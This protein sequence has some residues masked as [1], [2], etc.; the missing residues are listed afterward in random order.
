MEELKEI[1]ESK[2]RIVKILKKQNE[3]L[4]AKEREVLYVGSFG[5]GKSLALC[6]K[7]LKHAVI[8]NNFCLLTRK[9]RASLTNSTLRTLLIGET[10]CPPVLPQGSYEYLESKGLI[11][12]YGGSDIAIVGC[13]NSE[14]IRSINAGSIFIDECVELNYDEYLAL[15]GRLRLNSDPNRQICSATN[16]GSL[17]HWLYKRF[18]S[19]TNENRKVIQ[20]SIDDNHFL[21]EDYVK[22][23]KLLTGVNYQRYVLGNFCSNEKAVY[24]DFNPA[25]HIG[26][27]EVGDYTKFVI[28]VDVGF[29]DPTCI[30]VAGYN[31]ESAHVYEEIYDNKLTPTDICNTIIQLKEKYINIKSIV[32]DPSA[33]GT[34]TQMEQ[35]NI[36]NVKKAFNSID[37]GIFRV[38]EYLIK[39]KLTMSSKCINLI[40]EFDIYSYGDKEKPLD[41]DNHAMDSIRYLVSELYDGKQK[42][43]FPKIYV[44]GEEVSEDEEVE[45]EIE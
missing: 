41:V 44:D 11:H 21:P 5:S 1:E 27:K 6:Y 42:F 31:N 37:E 25:L 17:N 39:N 23:Q 32:I 9:T 30:L 14:K 33:A 40:K 26:E 35:M 15:L 12:V 24:K 16:P 22:E 3:F 43:I 28:S 38:T 4:K 2:E 29:N 18:F 34:R 7:L 13:D 10:N 20:A 45:E 19:D 8:P 36:I